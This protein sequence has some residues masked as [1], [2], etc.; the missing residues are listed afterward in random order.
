MENLTPMKTLHISIPK[1]CSE[2]WDKM[3]AQEKGRFC[4]TC[5]K[6]VV[7]FTEKTPAEIVAIL[8]NPSGKMCGR[9]RPDQLRSYPLPETVPFSNP[10]FRRHFSWQKWAA[11][12]SALVVWQ[13]TPAFSQKMETPQSQI[14]FQ[15]NTRNENPTEWILRGRVEDSKT[16]EGINLVAIN[17]LGT[18]LRSFSNSQGEFSLDLSALEQKEIVLEFE[19][20]FYRTKKLKVK[21]LK[22]EIPTVR[23]KQKSLRNLKRGQVEVI[24]GV[25]LEEKIDKVKPNETV[26]GIISETP[27]FGADTLTV[28]K[29]MYT[30]IAFEKISGGATPSVEIKFTEESY[31]ILD[32]WAMFLIL[33]KAVRIEIRAHVDGENG[34]FAIRL[35]N[36]RAKAISDYLA[37]KS[38][39][40]YR[41]NSTGYGA[42]LPSAIGGANERIEFKILAITEE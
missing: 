18:N 26:G 34:E 20:D 13:G 37:G 28:D 1:P 35:T 2:D 31:D 27:V 25:Y 14:N 40:N 8:Q 23:L 12:L 24:M 32:R 36:N 5:S 15:K 41:L 21:Y 19:S 38:V 3:T 6:T 30:N 29:L 10:E 42:T 17:I 16:G 4:A 7:D 9:F 11:M 33:N 39:E 22:K